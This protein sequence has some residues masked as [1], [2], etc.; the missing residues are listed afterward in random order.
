MVILKSQELPPSVTYQFRLFAR[1]D[2]HPASGHEGEWSLPLVSAWHRTAEAV[3]PPP[4]PE[5]AVAPDPPPLEM[6]DEGTVLLR[7][8]ELPGRG[9]DPEAA[10]P[11]PFQLQFR[12]ALECGTTDW[13]LVQS[14]PLDDDPTKILV[15]DPRLRR[16]AEDG[17]I[18]R[19][20]RPQLQFGDTHRDDA[21]VRHYTSLASVPSTAIRSCS[22]QFD[23]WP[24]ATL[25]FQASADLHEEDPPP[26]AMLRL[27]WK[28]HVPSNA[29]LMPVRLHQVRFRRVKPPGKAGMLPPFERYVALENAEVRREIPLVGPNFLMGA[30]YQVSVRMGTSL[31]W[32][33]WSP[34]VPVSLAIHPPQPAV[35]G[36]LQL[37]DV[38][39]ED[40]ATF[41]RLTWPAF[42]THPLCN[43]IEYRIRMKR[44]SHYRYME[45]LRALQLKKRHTWLAAFACE[46]PNGVE[47]K[48]ETL[49]FV[50]R[51]AADAEC[52]YRFFVDAKHE[53][54]REVDGEQDLQREVDVKEPQWMGS[55]DSFLKFAGEQEDWSVA[56]ESRESI[57]PPMPR[58]SYVPEQVPVDADPDPETRTPTVSVLCETGG[59][60]QLKISFPLRLD[61]AD[62]DRLAE[63]HSLQLLLFAPW[64]DRIDWYLPDTVEYLWEAESQAPSGGKGPEQCAFVLAK[65]FDKN[66]WETEMTRQALHREQTK[67]LGLF[68][69]I[70]VVREG[71]PEG[72]QLLSSPSRPLRLYMPAINDLNVSV[73]SSN[74]RF[75]ALL[76]WP[77]IVAL[78]AEKDKNLDMS[79]QLHQAMDHGRRQKVSLKQVLQLTAKIPK[80]K[81]LECSRNDQQ[82]HSFQAIS[83]TFASRRVDAM[84]S[85]G[86]TLDVKQRIDEVE[87]ACA[88]K[89]L[90]TGKD[91]L[92][93]MKKC[94]QELRA[95][96]DEVAAKSS[97]DL[98]LIDRI[99]GLSDIIY[100]NLE[101]RITLELVQLADAADVHK[102]L[103]DIAEDLDSVR[104]TRVSP[105][106]QQK[107]TEAEQQKFAQLLKELAELIKGL[108]DISKLPEA[109]DE[110]N[111][112]L[113]ALLQGVKKELAEKTLAQCSGF[114]TAK[115]GKGFPGLLQKEGP[116][117]L[118]RVRAPVATFD[119]SAQQVAAVAEGSWEALGPVLAKQ[120]VQVATHMVK[121]SLQQAAVELA[122]DNFDGATAAF[123]QMQ[124]WWPHSEGSE[125][126]DALNDT[127]AE[128]GELGGSHQVVSCS[129]PHIKESLGKVLDLAE[130][131]S[132]TC[133]AESI[134]DF[135]AK[136]DALC[137]ALAVERAALAPRLA[138]RRALG[139]LKQ[140]QEEL[141]KE[142]PNLASML[143]SLKDMAAAAETLATAE[144][145]EAAMT[146]LEDFLQQ[147]SQSIEADLA[148]VIEIAGCYDETRP[149]LSLPDTSP[150]LPR[151]QALLVSASLQRAREEL[152][153]E[154]GLNPALVLQ[155]VKRAGEASAELD[156]EMM[157]LLQEVAD[158][159]CERSLGMCESFRSAVAEG[160]DA[161]VQGLLKFAESFD[162]ACAAAKGSSQIQ[163]KLKEIQAAAAEA[164]ADE[165]TADPPADEGT[166]DPAAEGTEEP[167]APEASPE[168]TAAAAKISQ[169]EE[170]LSQETGMNPN[171]IL[172][173]LTE[174]V[175][176]WPSVA[177]QLSERLATQ[178]SVLQQRMASACAAASAEDQE[179]KLKALLAF[180]H[181]VHDL[182]HQ[183]DDCAPDFNFAVCSAGAAQDLT[184]AETE[185]GK[186]TGMN[187]V[188]V[189]K[190]IRNLRLYW[191]ALGPS[192]EQLHQR[193][194]AMCDL[195][196]SR[197]TTSYEQNPEK[198][199][200]LLKFSA[201][202]DA[203]IKDL[204]GAGEANLAERLQAEGEG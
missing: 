194:G 53:R 71:G 82:K 186:E 51:V 175:E 138:E 68:A 38:A 113:E 102:A 145:L 111:Q 106:V 127:W 190:N 125:E 64:K 3:P 144:G 112:K 69:R 50:H 130:E 79:G 89:K 48:R 133:E 165:G 24:K 199:P 27:D 118:E 141:E 72:M 19:L 174:L 181:K 45:R 32:G 109:L 96:M 158:K 88:G 70:R 26:T 56:M 21:R 110:V 197:I 92:D 188:A 156:D 58:N 204:D 10:R 202:F 119:A 5:E 182:Q 86:S 196:R 34:P 18:F 83:A 54:F 37:D 99:G 73:W 151:I 8:P 200:N 172:K 173:D 20:W 7:F 184:D 29:G 178:L 189:L 84:G 95:A 49:E 39:L 46:F 65:G 117:L 63:P 171:V 129:Q 60:D 168:Y 153:K 132:F 87:K 9:E 25:V 75:C 77:S 40:G 43:L 1:L 90:G 122:Q 180:A 116:D 152:C 85:G 66:L 137:S 42:D 121:V 16:Y 47:R 159:T 31:R 143:S 135:A 126:K 179:A 201:A 6:L 17:V 97:P 140:L 131:R 134:S 105:K 147:K 136:L 76:W 154:H 59:N 162:A 67:A 177:T 12:G 36:F 74:G 104:A 120:S 192:A 115:F 183:M 150:L 108:T 101:S 191:Q 80:F 203:A 187:P 142:D 2:F 123:A 15:M 160:Q 52:G 30:D 176:L 94:S 33:D 35:E 146:A 98:H 4:A 166:D 81:G 55:W 28:V 61:E 198:R 14:R 22:P 169:M 57:V 44:V 155:L 100:S 103:M 164:P 93:V 78:C 161:K 128:H 167:A 157:A 91:E 11:A 62:A 124:T 149:K 23:A 170:M 185:L 114:S 163:E 41:F 195:M 107:W 139:P 13:Q 193:L 148:K